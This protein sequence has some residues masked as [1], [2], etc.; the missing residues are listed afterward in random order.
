MV[1]IEVLAADDVLQSVLA[2]NGDER[3]DELWRLGSRGA[4]ARAGTYCRV[5]DGGMLSTDWVLQPVL[6]PHDLMIWLRY[7]C[8]S[9][10]WHPT[11]DSVLQP[12]L[13]LAAEM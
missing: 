3:G 12:V 8:F 2:P 11:N 9:P 10:C 6:A 4:S 5:V 13:A 1:C 7:M